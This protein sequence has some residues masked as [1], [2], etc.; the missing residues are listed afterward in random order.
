MIF[1]RYLT[2][3]EFPPDIFTICMYL[4]SALLGYIILFF[5]NFSFG[6]LSFYVTNIW[7]I[8]NLKYAVLDFLSGA[9][10]PIAFLPHVIQ[11]IMD[12]VPFASINYVPV[13][14][15][16]GKVSG[17]NILKT[18]IMQSVWIFLLFILS[19]ILWNKATKRL[20]IL[21]G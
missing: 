7:G 13:T 1:I 6:I 21:G 20:T 16:L 15:Y 4:L 14:I 18:L 5:V 8:R 12:F 10:V 11:R 17:L 2:L 3:S 19:N 9:I